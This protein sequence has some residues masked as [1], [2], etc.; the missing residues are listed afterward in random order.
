MDEAGVEFASGVR[1]L[2]KR[3][4]GRRVSFARV[5]GVC[6]ATYIAHFNYFCD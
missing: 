5:H 1:L 2:R 3:N 6:P 4:C